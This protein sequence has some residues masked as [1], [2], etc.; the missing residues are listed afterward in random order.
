MSAE[1]HRSQ[2][3][4]YRKHYRPAAYLA[5]KVVSF[6]GVGYWMAR[7]ALGMLRGRVSAVTVWRRL[8]SYWVIVRA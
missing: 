4:F 5:L 2:A 6:L 3:R 7:T 1:F 8:V